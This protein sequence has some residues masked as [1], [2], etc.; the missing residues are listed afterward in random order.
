MEFCNISDIIYL[1]KILA[2]FLV[3][4]KMREVSALI[5]AG[6]VGDRNMAQLKFDAKAALQL[7]SNY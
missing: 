5:V 6:L 3:D 2:H 1:E 7:P 4:V